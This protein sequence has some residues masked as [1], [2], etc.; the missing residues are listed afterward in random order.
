MVVAVGVAAEVVAVPAAPAEA[1]PKARAARKVT[2]EARTEA[3]AMARAPE[4]S[5]LNHPLRPH[6]A[7]LAQAVKGARENAHAILKA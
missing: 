2:R 7:I 6:A 5:Q 1:K 3:E 4:V